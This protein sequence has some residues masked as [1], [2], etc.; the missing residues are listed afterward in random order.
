MIHSRK[1]INYRKKDLMMG[2]IHI[3]SNLDMKSEARSVLPT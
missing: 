2:L 1:Y 3:G